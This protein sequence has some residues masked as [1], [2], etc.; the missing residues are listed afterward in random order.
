MK[1]YGEVDVQIHVFMNL[2]LDGGEWS[3]S[4]SVRFTPGETFQG[5]HLIGGGVG[6]RTSMDDM[7]KRIFLPLLALELRLLGRP[8]SSQSLHRLSYIISMPDPSTDLSLTFGY[9]YKNYVQISH[10][11]HS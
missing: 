4:R 11:Y 8:A 9:S 5:T 1:A 3:A 6:P 7:E 2:E 10:L